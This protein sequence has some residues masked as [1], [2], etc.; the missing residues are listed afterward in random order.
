[1]P[2]PNILACVVL[3][4]TEWFL[5]N[6]MVKNY[7]IINRNVRFIYVKVKNIYIIE[8]ICIN[9]LIILKFGKSRTLK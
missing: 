1:M 2:C 5:E 6:K 9:E 3:N 8:L 4:I 7:L